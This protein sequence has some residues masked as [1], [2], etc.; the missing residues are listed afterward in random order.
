VEARAQVVAVSP[1]FEPAFARLVDTAAV[2]LIQRRYTVED[3]A[4][5]TLVVAATDDPAVNAQVSVDA[6]R[7]GVLVSVVDNP[8]ESDFIV[9]AIVRR[10]DLVLAISTGGRSPALARHLRRELD[11][12]V[13]DDWEVLVRLLGIA[14]AKVQTAVENPVRRQELM[15]QLITLDVL[16]KLRNEGNHAAMDQ[17]DALIAGWAT[18]SPTTLQAPGTAAE[19]P[20]PA[21]QAD[22]LPSDTPTPA[23]PR[24]D[25][26]HSAPSFP[27]GSVQT[28]ETPQGR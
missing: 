22:S 2:T 10:G 19:T 27:P 8:R 14:R 13:P 7:A 3:L 12:L 20:S 6:R 4:G 11:L 28:I 24:N 9:P 23:P 18:S 1:R 15:K 25:T 17:I 5:M 26:R 21:E 16:S